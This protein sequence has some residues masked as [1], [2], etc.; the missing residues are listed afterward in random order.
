[1]IIISR[2]SDRAFPLAGKQAG[3]NFR[4]NNN[5]YLRNFLVK[6]E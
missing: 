5:R 3:K 2:K 6:E 4:K 1:M